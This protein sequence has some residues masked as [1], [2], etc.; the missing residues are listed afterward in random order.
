MFEGHDF[1]KLINNSWVLDLTDCTGYKV[2]IDSNG[3]VERYTKAFD[4]LIEDGNITFEKYISIPVKILKEA[5]NQVKE[6]VL[7]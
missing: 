7:I 1:I 2:E 3:E 5:T 6:S 4:V